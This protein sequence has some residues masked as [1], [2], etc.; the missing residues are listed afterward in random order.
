M[1]VWI[2]ILLYKV[3]AKVGVEEN[4]NCLIPN[5]MKSGCWLL[6]RYVKQGRRARVPY[7]Q[8]DPY[9]K[10]RFKSVVRADDK[11]VNKRFFLPDY[12]FFLI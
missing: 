10:V 2:N 1:V 7:E 3:E 9:I 11:S 4:F 6:K 8:K 12:L 5:Q